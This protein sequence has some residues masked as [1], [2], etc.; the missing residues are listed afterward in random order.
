MLLWQSS[1]FIVLATILLSIGTARYSY[2]ASI[3]ASCNCVAFRLD[4]IQDYFLNNVSLH[5]I[6]TFQNNNA[7]L[8]I[9]IIGNYFGND[10]YLVSNLKDKIDNNDTTSNNPNPTLEIANHG[11]NHEDFT[12]FSRDEQYSLIQKSNEKIFEKL[13]VTPIVF[14]PPY[15]NL[16]NDTLAAAQEN[17]MKYISANTTTSTPS[18]LATLPVTYSNQSS[19]LESGT[20]NTI[21]NFPSLAATGDINSD[22]TK[23]VGYSH[24]DTF[25]AVKQSMSSLGYA[26]V[27][28]HPQEY[29]IRN[30]LNYTNK[31]DNNQ[32]QELQSLIDSVHTAGLKIVTISEIDKQITTIP[33]FSSNLI[34]LT[35]AIL[36]FP[37]TLVLRFR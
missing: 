4:D 8:T 24:E 37:I 2:A 16:N 23:W 14:I 5:I 13:R 31:V 30:G 22:N 21:A 3:D 36:L 26:V 27:T 6:Q 1:A 18:S 10:L 12:S 17:G 19:T 28:M 7:S 29:S 33:E 25:K 9:G 35:A 20:E 32:L 11:W 34:V 15:N